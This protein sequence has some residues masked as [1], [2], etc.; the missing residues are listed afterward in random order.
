MRLPFAYLV[1][2]PPPRDR[3]VW[4][5]ATGHALRGVLEARGWTPRARRRPVRAPKRSPGV[6]ATCPK[7]PSAHPD[8][9]GRLEAASRRRASPPRCTWSRCG[10]LRRTFAPT[11]GDSESVVGR[12]G[13]ARRVPVRRHEVRRVHRC[14]DAAARGAG[15]INL[16][17]G[18]R[19]AVV[20]LS[21]LRRPQ[22]AR[23]GLEDEQPLCV[24]HP[25][26]PLSTGRA[27]LRR[28]QGRG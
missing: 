2:I 4:H 12:D 8:M 5:A 11:L 16:S 28:A 17:E 14:G 7:G 9:L 27:W 13:D 25:L 15:R 10:D 21:L 1:S 20:E 6:L 26:A 19:L 24:H 18:M 3:T 23:D 22:G